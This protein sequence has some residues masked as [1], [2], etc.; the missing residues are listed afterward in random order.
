MDE[1]KDELDISHRFDFKRAILNNWLK[2]L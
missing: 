1:Y 2:A